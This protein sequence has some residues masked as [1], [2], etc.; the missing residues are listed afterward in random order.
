VAWGERLSPP[1]AAVFAIAGSS[2]AIN[3]SGGKSSVNAVEA[4]FRGVAEELRPS[5][6]RRTLN[7]PRESTRHSRP[8]QDQ[9]L[10]LPTPSAGF[11]VFGG[12]QSAKDLPRPSAREV[13]QESKS[14]SDGPRV[15]QWRLNC[16]ADVSPG[17]L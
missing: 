6:E 1:I 16:T 13:K 3:G 8:R 5:A 4:D 12:D 17:R 7:L 14:G 11:R 15:P 2:L 9:A 10:V